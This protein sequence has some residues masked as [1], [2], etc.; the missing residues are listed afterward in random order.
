MSTSRILSNLRAGAPL[1]APSLLACDFA[2][3]GE[4]IRRVARAGAKV[5]PLDI[6]DG[7]FVPNLS[8]GLPVVEAIRRSTDLPLD[9][10]L[11]VSE[12]ARYA[13]RFREAGADLLTF[14]IEAVPD[15]RALLDEIHSLGVAAGLTLNP[16]TPVE[17]IE[18]FLAHCDL[19]LVM[20]VM[21]GFG[22]QTF[23]PSALDKLRRLRE[24]GGPDLLLSVDGGVN[25]KTA[26]RCL[27]AGADLLV[28]GS[29]LFSQDDYGRFLD[30]IAE[31][32]R[33]A[34]NF[35]A[36]KISSRA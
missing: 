16:P 11:M 28:I 18:P 31:L 34:K 6:M 19:V 30:T 23:D 2:C 15:P 35:S 9:V 20:S 24:V 22:G 33:N 1:A 26:P 17:S 29:A 27:D 21:A 32:A 10:H 7:H 3:V 8:F 12:P 36:R 25:L 5:L 4:E 13:A 14:H